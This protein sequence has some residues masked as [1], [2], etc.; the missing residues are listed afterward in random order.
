MNKTADAFRTISEVAEELELPQHVLR[1]WETRFLQ[2]KPMKRAGGRRYYR[3]HDIELLRAIK[4]LLYQE[5]YTIR[6]VQRVLK[7]NPSAVFPVSGTKTE[8]LV[9]DPVI[10]EPRD[11]RREPAPI[12]GVA[13]QDANESCSS[14][15]LDPAGSPLTPEML[16][17]L[18]KAL[19][20]VMECVDT[21]AAA[22]SRFL[23]LGPSDPKS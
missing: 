6:G 21:L 13:E 10:T 16:G 17:Q 7:E 22:R 12:P 2:I 3:P 15:M 19:V 1:F 20:E 18:R 14:Q 9:P 23:I 11:L 5:G 4:H 8:S